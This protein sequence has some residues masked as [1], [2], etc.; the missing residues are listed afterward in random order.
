MVNKIGIVTSALS[1][2]E[3]SWLGKTLHRYM[4]SPSQTDPPALFF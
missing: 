2:S 4:S 3:H 1:D